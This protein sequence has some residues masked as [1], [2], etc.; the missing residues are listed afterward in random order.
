MRFYALIIFIFL[1]LPSGSQE[2]FPLMEPASTMPK[3]T[4]GIR[5]MNESYEEVGN[6]FR[7]QFALRA[8][9][10][11]TPRL[12]VY[13]TGDASNHHNRTLPPDFPTHNTP[14]VGV[15]HPFLFNGY[16][17]YAKY[18]F[19]SIDGE[20][21]HFR[22]ALYGEWSNLNV[23]HDEAE[24]TL[25]DDTKGYGGGLITT[26]LKKRFAISFTGGFI[27]PSEY[28]G[29]VT[30]PAG[31]PE[32]PAKVDY[33]NAINYDLSI[34]YLL[35]PRKYKNYTQTNWNL[36][37]EFLG[38]SYDAAKVY[39]SNYMYSIP[40]Y[41]VP[42]AL[43]PVLQAGNYIEVHPG[44]QCIINSNFRADLSVGFPLLNKSF[45]HYYPVYTIGI[46][47]YFYFNKKKSKE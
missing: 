44:L 18:R 10:G 24:P 33:G 13:F 39:F 30:D 36:Y 19:L 35:F 17:I 37:L 40:F 28:N 14:Q 16:N 22:A 29:G 15:H 5:L 42:I 45:V 3:H 43:V 6:Q 25:L 21:S 7:T 26:Y 11:I 27:I 12:S 31:L 4:L 41:A 47:R 46:Q 8:M 34:G 1:A 2:L 32:I 38:K 9:Y 20:N 23:A